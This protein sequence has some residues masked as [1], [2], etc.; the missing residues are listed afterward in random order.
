M[1]NNAAPSGVVPVELDRRARMPL[2]ERRWARWLL[3]VGAG[4][5]AYAGVRRARQL[6]TVAP[7]LRTPALIPPVTYNSATTPVFRRLQA[8]APA[9]HVPPSLRLTERWVPSQAGQPAVRLVTLERAASSNAKPAVLWLHG[10]GHVVGTPEQDMTLLTR[11]LERLDVLIVCV[12][13]RLAPEHPFPAALNDAC[14]AFDWLAEHAG[15][16]SVDPTRLAIGGASAG[17]GLAAAVVQRV[18]DLG[19]TRPAFQLLM[20]PMLDVLTTRRKKRSNVGNFVWTTSSNRFGW[21]SYLGRGATSRES[22]PY[23]VPAWRHELAGLPP[24]WIGVGTLDLFHDEDVEYGQRLR[25]AGVDCEILIVDR[26]YHAFD[27][28]ASNAG[29]TRGFYEAMFRSLERGLGM[30]QPQAVSA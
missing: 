5:A 30:T 29:V 24:A 18:V 27:I 11:M 13:Y 23:A 28:F 4:T 22:A 1:N 8:M 12:D 17:G 21:N 3:A 26:A 25:A 2:N 16:L 20:Y 9:P 10:G 7:S 15:E 6:L 14:A 19:T